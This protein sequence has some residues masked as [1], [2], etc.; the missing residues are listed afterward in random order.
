MIWSQTC[1]RCAVA[2]VVMPKSVL[3]MESGDGVLSRASAPS[4][5]SVW[6][7][8][9]REVDVDLL[10]LRQPLQKDMQHAERP[11]CVRHAAAAYSFRI[12]DR[13]RAIAI[14]CS[15]LWGSNPRPYAYE[16]HALPTELKRLTCNLQ[17][18]NDIAPWP[19]ARCMSVHFKNGPS[20]IS[21]SMGRQLS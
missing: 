2:P 3:K 14:M 16:A 10:R 7:S 15:P 13:A 18:P 8:R 5:R 4:K 17:A 1:C 11:A 6:S 19:Q 21:E 12:E 9:V 20:T